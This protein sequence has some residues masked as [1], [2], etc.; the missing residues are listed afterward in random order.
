M[1]AKAAKV[2][3]SRRSGA[4]I[5][6]AKASF[7]AGSGGG[8]KR[9]A[10]PSALFGSRAGAAQRLVGGGGA[11]EESG[12]NRNLVPAICALADGLAAQGGREG[13]LDCERPIGRVDREA[14]HGLFEFA[15]RRE[16]APVDAV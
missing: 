8:K 2:M 11:F 10:A 3:R 6:S 15:S 13:V 1:A 7:V 5:H 12:L 4:A 9:T 16:Q 14:F